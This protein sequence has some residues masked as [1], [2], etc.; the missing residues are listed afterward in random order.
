MRRPASQFQLPHRMF[1]CFKNINRFYRICFHL[2]TRLFL[3]VGQTSGLF[4]FRI[5]Q[6]TGAVKLSYFL[7]PY[8]VI[9]GIII[10]I[11]TPR[12]IYFILKLD[13]INLSNVNILIAASVLE[14]YTV[15]LITCSAYWSFLM[16]LKLA[17]SIVRQGMNLYREGLKLQSVWFHNEGRF[18]FRMIYKLF[19][20]YVLSSSS[21]SFFLANY[22]NDDYDLLRYVLNITLINFINSMLNNAYIWGI[23]FGAHLYRSINREIIAITKT[24]NE[25]KRPDIGKSCE[26]S[27]AIDR[28]NILHT[29]VTQYT[30]DLNQ[31]FGMQNMFMFLNAFITIVAQV[32]LLNN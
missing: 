13:N 9:Y 22:F 8:G 17:K 19:N 12:S 26:L 32:R 29:E 1:K 3:F 14:F 28:L 7:L 21:I 11:V 24:I 27:D 20:V 5:N 31:L 23:M 16:N 6:A 10:T 25:M 2:F 30:R 18:I 4:Y 15:Y